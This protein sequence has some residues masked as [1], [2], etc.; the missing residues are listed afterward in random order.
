L[1]Q[2]DVSLPHD[3]RYYGLTLPLGGAEVSMEE[4]VRLYGALAN[5]GELRPLRR[6]TNTPALPGRRILSPEACFLTL[7]MLGHVPRPEVNCADA[8]GSAPVYWK[9]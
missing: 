9:T 7:E 8:P 3:E 4:L 1:K 6:L 2:C 5:N